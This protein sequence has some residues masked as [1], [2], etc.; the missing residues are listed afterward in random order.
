MES[1]KAT[2]TAKNTVQNCYLGVHYEK[3]VSDGLIQ[4]KREV[5]NNENQRSKKVTVF[6]AYRPFLVI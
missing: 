5:A 4:L 2:F 3:N 6:H 1:L